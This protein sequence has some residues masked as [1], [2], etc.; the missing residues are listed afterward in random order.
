ML[1]LI[2]IFPTVISPNPENAEAL[3]MAVNL[4]KEIDADLVMASD[5]D[6]ARV[7]IACKDDKGEWAV[8]YTHLDVY[9]RQ[10]LSLASN[11]STSLSISSPGKTQREKN[12]ASIMFA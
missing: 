12:S 3:S 8:S 4:A 1:S 11:D 9:K 7:G 2:H 6:A 5:P 10:T